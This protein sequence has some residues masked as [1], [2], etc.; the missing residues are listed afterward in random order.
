MTDQNS[1]ELNIDLN[2]EICDADLDT[3]AGGNWWDSI[4]SFFSH[5]PFNG[6]RIISEHGAGVISNDGGSFRRR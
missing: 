4:F 2:E 6:G 3:V 5:G 1:T